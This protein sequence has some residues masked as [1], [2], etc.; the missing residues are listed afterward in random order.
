MTLA[1]QYIAE[2]KAEMIA[3]FESVRPLTEVERAAIELAFTHGLN[4]ANEY[5]LKLQKVF[6]G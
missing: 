4:A 6:N 5:H 2:K 3:F 1:D